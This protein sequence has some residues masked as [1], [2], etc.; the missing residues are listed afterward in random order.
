MKINYYKYSVS[1]PYKKFIY[2][3][4]ISKNILKHAH[5]RHS[6]FESVSLEL[7]GDKP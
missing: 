2:I 4:L 3:F 6:R 1:Y 7:F 5:T